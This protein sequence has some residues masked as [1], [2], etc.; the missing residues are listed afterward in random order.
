MPL[1]EK[2]GESLQETREARQWV[3]G[4]EDSQN[5]LGNAR[6]IG[7]ISAVV[8]RKIFLVNERICPLYFSCANI[9]P[10]FQ[11]GTKTWETSF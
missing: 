11:G 8:N 7:G 4:F 1:I 2:A 5:F 3:L 6:T 10:P 9:K